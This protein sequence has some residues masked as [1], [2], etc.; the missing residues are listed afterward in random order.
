MHYLQHLQTDKVLAT[1]CTQAFPP[2]ALGEN[3][4]L[5]L[6]RSILSQQLSTRVAEI[7]FDRFL[8]LFKSTPTCKGI[9]KLDFDTLK[10]IGLSNN[11]TQY[12]FNVAEFFVEEKLTDDWFQHQTN[13]AIIEKLTQIK[14]VGKWTVEMLLMFTLGRED[15]FAV[16]DLGIQHAMCKLYKISPSPKKDMKAAMLQIS[17]NWQPFR[18]Y[19]CLHLWKWKDS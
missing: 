14:G 6:V 13:E 5:A 4:A 8:L 7:L 15:V 19:A 16:D 18:S 12:V 17:L 1:I 2:L 11:K 9:L 10:G 3:V